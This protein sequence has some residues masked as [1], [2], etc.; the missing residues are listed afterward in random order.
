MRFAKKRFSALKFPILSGCTTREALWYAFLHLLS[1][2]ISPRLS[3]FQLAS[4]QRIVCR[5]ARSARSCFFLPCSSLHALIFGSKR[6]RTASSSAS[7][8]FFLAS[9]SRTSATAF[10][11]DCCISFTRWCTAACT[12]ADFPA[13]FAGSSLI[14]TAFFFCDCAEDVGG[15]DVVP[16]FTPALVSTS[17]HLWSTSSQTRLA[18][19]CLA[20]YSRF[21]RSALVSLGNDG[22]APPAGCTPRWAFGE[23]NP[24]RFSDGACGLG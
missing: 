8:I 20:A 4:G 24:M 18:F 7:S 1:S 11:C 10:C 14:P 19:C 23:S 22:A 3:C 16:C 6:F 5:E 15:A 9:L 13:A 2:R 17:T 12:A 21:N